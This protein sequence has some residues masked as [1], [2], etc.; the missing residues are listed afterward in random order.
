MLT[1]A[2]Q[3]AALEGGTQVGVNR[4]SS[5]L[6]PSSFHHDDDLEACR[7][8][9]LSLRSQVSELQRRLLRV[10]TPQRELASGS[11][12][13]SASEREELLEELE[14]ARYEVELL[15]VVRGSL[16]R[17]HSVCRSHLRGPR[18]RTRTRSR[19]N[20]TSSAFSVSVPRSVCSCAPCRST[21]YGREQKLASEKHEGETKRLKSSLSTAEDRTRTLD[22][23]LSR[24][25]AATD[26]R[27]PAGLAAQL[28]ANNEE[29]DGVLK[30]ERAAAESTLAGVQH[31]HREC[32]RRWCACP[33]SQSASLRTS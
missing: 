13:F 26:A 15:T 1:L 31:K 11:G 28:K 2:L 3:V 20:S 33:S 14:I 5:S 29:W 23:E 30:K 32:E 8:E 17:P 4:P 9:C 24:L 12:M 27:S 25:R 18:H 21:D 16:G 19:R 22:A 6:A 7:I 10:Q